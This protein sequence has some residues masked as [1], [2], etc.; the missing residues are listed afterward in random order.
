MSAYE[1]AFKR[2]RAEFVEMPGMRLTPEQA[3]R[4]SGVGSSVC[5]RVLDDLVRAGVLAVGANGTYA[6]STGLDLYPLAHRAQSPFSI[7]Q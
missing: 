7:P 1:Q 4:L 5:R 2:I 3:E 6:R